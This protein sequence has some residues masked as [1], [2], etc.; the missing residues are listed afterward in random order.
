VFVHVCVLA[1]GEPVG[2]CITS[3]WGFGCWQSCVC[4]VA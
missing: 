4:H 1:D 3:G 2:P